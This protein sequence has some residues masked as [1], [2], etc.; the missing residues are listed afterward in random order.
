[1]NIRTIDNRAIDIRTMGRLPSAAFSAASTGTGCGPGDTHRRS[2]RTEPRVDLERFM[3]RW[4]VIACI[5]TLIER[6]AHNAIEHYELD[7]DGTIATTFS[8]RKGDFGGRRKSYTSRGF[9][10]DESNAVWGMRFIWPVK[11]D[12]RIVYVD[13]DYTQTIVGRQKRDYAWIMARTPA[14]PNGDYFQRVKL[15]REEGYDTS[16]LKLVPQRW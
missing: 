13:E 2:I 12:Y 10:R 3:G 9:V 16:R 7:Y 6:Y 4:Y 1:M 11:A 15:L 5:P 14:I 8:F